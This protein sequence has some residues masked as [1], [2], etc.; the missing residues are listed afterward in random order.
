MSADERFLE[1]INRIEKGKQWAPEGV[2]H[3]PRA[4]QVNKARRK[5]GGKGLTFG[6]VLLVLILGLLAA[7][8]E[9]PGEL[10]AFMAE[11][12]VA[13]ARTALISIP[14]IAGMIEP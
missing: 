5:R 13:T 12:S 14:F 6:I 10:S 9:T 2:V 4:A 8:E 1:R 7:P 3:Q 11:P